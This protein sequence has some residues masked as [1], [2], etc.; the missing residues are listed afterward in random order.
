[1]AIVTTIKTQEG[2]DQLQKF[3]TT[4][5]NATHYEFRKMEETVGVT[6]AWRENNL[7]F[8][9]DFVENLIASV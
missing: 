1:M 6:I 3:Q 7:K 8:V 4:A 5:T 9:T 2:L